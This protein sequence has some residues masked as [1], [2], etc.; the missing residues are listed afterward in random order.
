MNEKSIYCS[1]SECLRK[2][3]RGDVTVIHPGNF[4][5]YKIYYLKNVIEFF[6]FLSQ[7]LDKFR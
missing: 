6:S 3:A 5:G 4:F 7:E 2:S 1:I